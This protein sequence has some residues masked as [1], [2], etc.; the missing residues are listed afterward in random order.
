[1]ADNQAKTCSKE[2]KKPLIEPTAAS[3][4]TRAPFYV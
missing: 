1:M 3:A 2:Q 4:A